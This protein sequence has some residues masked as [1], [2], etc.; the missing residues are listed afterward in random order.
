MF[1]K[2]KSEKP[3]MTPD[4]LV[5][6]RRQSLKRAVLPE[7]RLITSYLRDVL[8]EK[9]QLPD[10]EFWDNILEV[11]F[12]QACALLLTLRAHQ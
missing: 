2:I 8:S 3:Q 7:G 10:W 12:W 9:H 1:K 4:E 5:E 11:E 6:F